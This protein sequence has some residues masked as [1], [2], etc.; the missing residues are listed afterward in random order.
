MGL[1]MMTNDMNTKE[2]REELSADLLDQ[3]NGGVTCTPATAAA[4]AVVGGVLTAGNPWGVG[5][6][7]VAACAMFPAK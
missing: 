4:G 7:A 2:T 5:I 1:G 6:G 3:V